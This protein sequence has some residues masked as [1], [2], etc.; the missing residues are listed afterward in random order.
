[1]CCHYDVFKDV[2]PIKAAIKYAKPL[3]ELVGRILSSDPMESDELAAHLH[4]AIPVP[5]GEN[6]RQRDPH[7]LL[8]ELAAKGLVND[9]IFN[10]NRSTTY[11]C[12][13]VSYQLQAQQHTMHACSQA[14]TMHIT[15]ARTHRLIHARIR[16]RARTQAHTLTHTH[17][18]NT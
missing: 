5:A 7:E 2:T 17:H 3:R 16:T 10:F 13:D 8:L 15:K 12:Q 18:K 11:R 6:N 14:R 4:A 9:R 1:M